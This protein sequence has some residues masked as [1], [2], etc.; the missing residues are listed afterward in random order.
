MLLLLTFTL[1]QAVYCNGVND[2]K[3]H[4]PI[5]LGVYDEK[6]KRLFSW[7]DRFTVKNTPLFSHGRA[8]ILQL[9]N[10]ARHS[11]VIIYVPIYPAFY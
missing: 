9:C 4:F 7:N 8:G 5:M 1:T 11:V 10:G 6:K 3:S 2:L